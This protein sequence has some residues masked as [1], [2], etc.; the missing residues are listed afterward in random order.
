MFKDP[1]EVTNISYFLEW[2]QSPISKIGTKTK[3]KMW[4]L[5]GPL[6]AKVPKFFK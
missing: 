4:R 3:S 2:D 6:G 1:V 5:S